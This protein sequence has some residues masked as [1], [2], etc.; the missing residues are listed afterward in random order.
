MKYSALLLLF[1]ASQIQAADWPLD[2]IT[3]TFTE[4]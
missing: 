4:G 2:D 1:L 3:D